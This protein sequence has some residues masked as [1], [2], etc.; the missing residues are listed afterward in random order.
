MNQERSEIGQ[1]SILQIIAFEKPDIARA[2]SWLEKT[3][4]IEQNSENKNSRSTLDAHRKTLLEER[5]QT[6]IA[7]GTCPQPQHSVLR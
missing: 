1:P 3:L 5:T 2:K 6:S 4:A 7:T